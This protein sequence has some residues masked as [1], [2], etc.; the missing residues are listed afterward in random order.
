MD[1]FDQEIA[2]K[3]ISIVLNNMLRAV[4]LPTK[5]ACSR[6]LVNIILRKAD[7][8]SPH[9]SDIFKTFQLCLFDRNHTARISFSA[10]LGHIARMVPT[11]DLILLNSN[12]KKKYFEEEDENN[13]MTIALVYKYI[14]AHANEKFVT[15]FSVFLPVVF[16]GKHDQFESVSSQFNETW[17]E[18]TGN[19]SSIILY[20]DEILDI[21]VDGLEN[22][23]WR[24]KKIAAVSLIEVIKVSQINKYLDKLLWKG[25]EAVLDA[26]IT[27]L[28]Y[29]EDYLLNKQGLVQETFDILIR[30]T[31]RND[32]N[33]RYYVLHNFNRFIEFR[34]NF[35]S[36][37]NI[38]SV[39]EEFISINSEK[40][41]TC[42]NDGISKPI[43]LSHREYGLRIIA[44]SFSPESD[45]TYIHYLELVRIWKDNMQLAMWNIQI[46]ICESIQKIF[47]Q[48]FLNTILFDK[49]N[50]S[51]LLDNWD[52]IFYALNNKKHEN[53]RKE[54]VKAAKIFIE[55]LR[56]FNDSGL[57]HKIF[58]AF[59]EL[60]ATETSPI[61]KI[62]LEHM[63]F[64]SIDEFENDEFLKA[65]FNSGLV[66]GDLVFLAQVFKDLSLFSLSY[67]HSLSKKLSEAGIS[68]SSSLNGFSHIS[69]SVGITNTSL[70][71]SVL[72]KT[73][74]GL[75]FDSLKLLTPKGK[76]TYNVDL[77][78]RIKIGVIRFLSTSYFS[79]DQK[80]VTL[81]I[82]KLDIDH[83]ISSIADV[84]LK[85]LPVINWED[86]KVIES[87]YD[88]LLGESEAP[89]TMRRDPVSPQIYV[90]LMSFLSKS[91]FAAT[92]IEN[93]PKLLNYGLQSDVQKLAEAT[94]IFVH[95]IART[96]NDDTLKPSFRC[97]LSSIMTYI[98]NS[99]CRNEVLREH[100]FT[101]IGLIA[102]RGMEQMEIV[103]LKFLF[104]FL[105]KETKLVRFSIEQSLS[106]I[107]PCFQNI[108]GNLLD[109]L[110]SLLFQIISSNHINMHFSALQYI[111]STKLSLKKASVIWLLSLIQ[112]CDESLAIQSNILSIQSAFISLLS[113]KD[114]LIQESA[115]KG[116][117]LLYEKGLEEVKSTLV[118]NLISCLITDKKNYRTVSPE[119]V[120]F[121]DE[122]LNTNS[123]SISTYGDVCKL[124]TEAGNP[125]LIYQFLNIASNSA[126][127]QSRQGA[128]FTINEIISSNPKMNIIE[129]D[130]ELV[131]KLI[132][133]LFLY[134][135]HPIPTIKKTMENIFKTVVDPEKMVQFHVDIINRLLK[136][137][138]DQSWYIREAS[139]NA[140]ANFFQIHVSETIQH[141][142]EDIIIMGFRGMDDVPL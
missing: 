15:L 69:S 58:A 5:L 95:W 45:K 63:D 36:F 30:E 80:F 17:S 85:K 67:F 12:L 107:M 9:A 109:E 38:Y 70:Q 120:L 72:K 135:F 100:L 101:S 81:T 106:L 22:S 32:N 88:L 86:E 108:Q 126:I 113:D 21:I 31:K 43:R 77:L 98:Q 103:V 28:C 129:N 87:I 110:N 62:E 13:L 39:V 40:V 59:N 24:L 3:I 122:I 48:K 105:E 138:N 71:L 51:T 82:F 10:S 64:S 29:N 18:N 6:V 52:I 118:Q 137:I 54:A 11:K 131:K 119:T 89:E 94:I 75:S 27:L 4:G 1:Q 20:L 7:Y 83:N 117:K 90:H 19:T 91:H 46:I 78:N 114:S 123:V 57:K 42:E 112:Y 97:I 16:L 47:K 128:V 25:K 124:A 141:Y 74:P 140:F 37:E 134:K 33:Y 8:V 125:E 26:F 49:L 136:G 127:W 53:V 99:D 102:Q 104:D 56:D 60:I 23:R 84:C 142:L 132:P 73:C 92:K 139:C 133:S 116:L 61:V 44:N 14:S 34:P 115:S 121:N 79:L 35:E 130:P 65:S 66:L 93:I 41:E 96:L 55:S 2:P 111:T 68:E 50:N 76:D